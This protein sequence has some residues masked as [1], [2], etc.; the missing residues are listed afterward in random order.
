M[1]SFLVLLAI[2]AAF[3]AIGLSGI[4]ATVAI[5]T[6]CFL[7][8]LARIAQSRD[9]HIALSNFLVGRLGGPDDR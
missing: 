7:G 8:I 2:V 9:Q 3:G 1:T 6:A 5:G 4:S